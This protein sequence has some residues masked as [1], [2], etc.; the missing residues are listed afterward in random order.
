MSYRIS[1]RQSSINPDEQSDPIFVIDEDTAYL[2]SIAA[3]LFSKALKNRFSDYGTTTGQWPLLLSL[4]E[5]DGLTQRQLS[6]RVQIEEPTT[7]RTLDRMERDGLVSRIRDK[8]DRRRIHIFLTKRASELKDELIPYAK[9]VNARAT[10]G[11]SEQD[12]AKA[13]SLLTYIIARLE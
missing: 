11:L 3:R 7:T 2:V 9:E 8:D 12:K 13:N 1:R 10:H 6:N 4:W 5:E